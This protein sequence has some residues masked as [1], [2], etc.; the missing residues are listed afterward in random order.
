MRL[1][2]EVMAISLFKERNL[3]F[4]KYA[5]LLDSVDFWLFS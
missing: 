1:D 4:L 5:M 2:Y 3:Q